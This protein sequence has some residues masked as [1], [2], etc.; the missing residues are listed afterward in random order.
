MNWAELSWSEILLVRVVWSELSLGRV[1][2][3]P[4]H[5]GL[6]RTIVF[7][8]DDPRVASTYFTARSNLVT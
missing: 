6:Q 4:Q 2:L 8:N 5:Q 1:V 7:S 3:H